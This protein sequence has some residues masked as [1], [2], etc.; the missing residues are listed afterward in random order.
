MGKVKL[1]SVA[2][3]CMAV[4]LSGCGAS[5]TVKGTGIGVGA[6]GAVGAGIGAIAGNTALGAVIGAAVGGTAGAL[7]G[8]KMDKQKQAIESQVPDATVESVNDGEALRVTFDSG[9]FFATNSSTVS[10]AAKTALAKFAVTLQQNP[11]TY[12]KIVGHTDSTGKVDYNQTLSEKRA[13]SVYDYL[14]LNSVANSRLTYEGKGI[15][16]PIADN[17]TAEGRALNRRVEVLIL[18]NEKMIQEAQQGTLN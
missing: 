1:L 5:N 18:A 7:I 16:Q 6:G 10:E 13:K 8:K 3:L 12:V 2:L 14:I 17:S 11:D 4:I 9:I 15:H